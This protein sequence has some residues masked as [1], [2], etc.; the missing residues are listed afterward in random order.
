MRE[1]LNSVELMPIYCYPF[2]QVFLMGMLF[3]F[4]GWCSEVVYVG[5]TSEHKFV[6]RGFFYGPICP[7]YGLGGLV[8]LLLPQQLYHTWI[9][10]FFASMVLC[11]AVEY[12]GSWIL[13]KMFHTLWWDYSHYKVNLKGRICLLNSVLFGIMGVLAI[14][15]VFPVVMW[16]FSLVSSTVIRETAIGIFIV[17]SVD[18]VFTIKRLVDF[19]T[20][21]EK[22]KEF[23]ESLKDH[24]EAEEWFHSES[25][26]AMM[27]SIKAKAESEK[28]KINQNLLEKIEKFNQKHHS[29]ESLMNRFPTMKS[30][31]YKESF[32]FTKGKIKNKIRK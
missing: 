11:S 23:G 12:F 7:I 25:L 14:H 16:L 17:F 10:L 18:A 29:T 27:N 2:S 4:V 22:L 30:T 6:N 24:Y 8:I 3:S 15:F 9:P 20:T 5:V 1:I 13:E 21:M 28:G 26:S 32:A 19:N 31:H